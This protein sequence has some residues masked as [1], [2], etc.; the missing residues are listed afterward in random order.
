MFE[1]TV[2]ESRVE[3]TSRTRAMTLPVSV[4]LHAAVIS[5]AVLASTWSVTMPKASP[6]QFR[7]LV[8]P[9]TPRVPLPVQPPRQPEPRQPEPQQQVRVDAP[10]AGPMIDAPPTS[11]PPTIPNLTPGQETGP[12]DRNAPFDWTGAGNERGGG[13]EDGDGTATTGP[14]IP[15]VGGVTKPITIK[16]VEP[17]YPPLLIKAKLNGFA[18]VECIVEEDGRITSAQVVDTNHPLFGEA[19]R[20]AVLQWKFLPG[21]LNGEPVP[22]IFNLTVKFE[23]RR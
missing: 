19:A 7:P 20:E 22:T 15:G 23:V 16:R 21:R 14:L 8:L 12:V 1:T 4:G 6:P 5:A 10:P 13:S 17:N 11:I 18:I 9:M 2:V 3:H